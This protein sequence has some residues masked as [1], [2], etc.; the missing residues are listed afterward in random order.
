[1]ER[2][3][4]VKKNKDERAVSISGAAIKELLKQ[5]NIKQVDLAH[6]LG[7]NPATLSRWGGPSDD[8]PTSTTFLVLIPLLLSVGV[9]LMPDYYRKA[10]AQEFA[11]VFS[12]QEMKKNT[13]KLERLAR[14][15]FWR[16]NSDLQRARKLFDALREAWQVLDAQHQSSK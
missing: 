8:M 3:I 4:T 7:V 9:D 11:S 1:M 16:A 14:E 6:L 13:P 12:A 15:R 10:V 5:K 2:K